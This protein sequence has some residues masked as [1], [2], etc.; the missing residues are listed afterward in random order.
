MNSIIDEAQSTFLLG[1]LITYNAIIAFEVFH[2]INGS[3][4]KMAPYMSLKLAMSMDFDRVKWR[5]LEILMR[6]MNFPDHF[7]HLIMRC[8]TTFCTLFF[9]MAFLVNH[10]LPLEVSNRVILYLPICLS[11]VL[12]GFRLSYVQ[13]KSWDL[14]GDLILIGDPPFL[15]S[16]LQTIR[17]CLVKLI[18]PSRKIEDHFFYLWGVR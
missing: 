17:F 1:R 8:I 6:K 18:F 3:P 15:T 4:S 14:F 2:S 7:T 5:F 13:Q 12:R 11:C 16:S 10:L 9:W